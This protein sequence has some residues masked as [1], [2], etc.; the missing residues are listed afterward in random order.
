MLSAERREI[1]K[2]KIKIEGR[3]LTKELCE[4]FNTTPVTIRKDLDFLENEGVLTKVHGGGI[5]KQ[6][7]GED[8]SVSEKEKL[9]IKEK[10]RIAKRAE[11]LISEGEVIILDYGFTSIHIA[12]RLKFRSGIKIITG[13]L[14]VANEIAGSD[15]ELILIGGIFNKNTFGLSGSF[16]ENVIKN[17]VSDKLF[18]GVDGVDIEKGLTAFNYEEAKLN[19]LMMKSATEKIL[20]TDSSKFGKRAMGY[21]GKLTEIDRIIT[22]RNLEDKFVK[23]IN[24]LDI[25]LDLV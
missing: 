25:K 15:N 24:E 10:E 22:D 4:K 6:S 1:I 16:A 18:L 11:S 3:V 12:R 9:H 21:I 2:Q 14:N 23:K 7:V 20:I 13:G 19:R 17:T 8:L 5:L